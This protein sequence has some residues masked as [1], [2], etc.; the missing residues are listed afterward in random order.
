MVSFDYPLIG[1]KG[2]ISSQE[3]A[4]TKEEFV[5]Q[6]VVRDSWSKAVFGVVVPRK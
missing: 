5:K 1:D 4:V 3:Q 6:L 2:K